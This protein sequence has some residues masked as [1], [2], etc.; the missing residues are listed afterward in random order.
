MKKKV[1]SLALALALCLG[2]VVPASAAAT[3]VNTAE[4]LQAAFDK[5]GDITLGGD[6]GV[7][8][9]LIVTR[10]SSLDLNGHKLTIIPSNRDVGLLI[11]LAQVLTI[12]DSQYNKFEPGNGQLKIS[13]VKSGIMTSGATLIINSGVIEVTSENEA[14]IGGQAEDGYHD[15][16]T[17]TINGGIVTATGG[18]YYLGDGAGIGGLG[19][20]YGISRSG[21]GGVITINGG[22]VTAVG[23]GYRA[24]GIGGGGGTGSGGG[25]GGTITIT[26]GLVR[27]TAGYNGA[28]IGHS[29]SQSAE[30]ETLK[31]TGGTIELV[32]SGLGASKLTLQNCTIKGEGAGDYAGSYD[33]SG[34]L[35]TVTG[36]SGWA[37]EAVAGAVAKGLV[38]Q[39]MQSDYTQS[40]TRAQFCALAVAFYEQATGEAI[41]QRKTFSDTSDPNIEKMGGLGIVSGVGGDRFDPNGTL[42][43]E[44][45]ATMLTRL[46]EAVGEPLPAQVASFADRAQISFWAAAAVGQVQGVGIMGGV[47]DNRFDP[48]GLYSREQSMITLLRLYELLK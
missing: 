31:I 38:P 8:E 34:N 5:G 32:Q 7:K 48:S 41:A 24:A 35:V 1:L 9:G 14:G 21:N 16:G 30:G 13:S 19:T 40:T 12:S 29:G 45:A 43:R 23:G 3:V 46:A 4:E 15:G 10:S 37:A 22:T 39:D 17:V 25:D 18:K 36:A 2:L 27:A 20:S 47:G 44:Q 6:I 33:A 11:E 26:G 28:A 42:T